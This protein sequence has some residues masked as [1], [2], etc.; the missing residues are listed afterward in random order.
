MELKFIL[1]AILF[2]TQKPL[3]V[4]ELRDIFS[5]T[6]EQSDD[7]NARSLRKIKE[8]D[9]TSALEALEKE[10]LAAKRSF[11]LVCVAGAW[12]FVSDPEYAPWLKILVG[13]KNRPP[14]LTQ[15]ALETLA[16]VAYRQPITRAEIEQIRG[17]AV[18]GVLATLA[19]R[20]L[21][22]QLGRAEVVGRPITYGTT[23]LF[24]EYFGL[25]DLD[26]LP[27][28]DELRRIVVAKPPT[29]LTTEPAPLTTD[30]S[31][32]GESTPGVP[33]SEGTAQELAPRPAPELASSHEHA[34]PGAS[35]NPQSAIRKS[36]SAG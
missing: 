12:Q 4:Q 23:A 29:L 14:R 10:H 25:R 24:L 2:N 26:E 9:L 34:Q 8:A 22:E 19:E 28:A 1:E 20:G 36:Q 31:S 18:D 15:P 5:S 32:A 21:I 3:S 13:A 17:V 33:S 35:E 30:S 27:A 11:R 16:I 6:A 7:A